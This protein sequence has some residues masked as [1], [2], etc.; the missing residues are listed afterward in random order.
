MSLERKLE[1]IALSMPWREVYSVRMHRFRRSLGSH[2]N[3]WQSGEGALRER[4]RMS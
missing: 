3:R 1:G 4:M 2:G